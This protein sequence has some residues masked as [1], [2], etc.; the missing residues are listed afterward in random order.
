MLRAE[1]PPLNIA[2]VDVYGYEPLG[3]DSSGN[4]TG[5]VPVYDLQVCLVT[6][7]SGTFSFGSFKYHDSKL[8]MF[9]PFLFWY[10]HI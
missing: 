7:R 9:W 6:E 8:T 1:I 3:Y 4:V 10:A 5:C 2:E